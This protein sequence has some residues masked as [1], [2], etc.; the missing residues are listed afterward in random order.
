MNTS[1]ILH[2]FP[3]NGLVKKGT[4]LNPTQCECNQQAEIT[5]KDR[6]A[7]L[8]THTSNNAVVFNMTTSGAYPIKREF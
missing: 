3:L 1:N 5:I 8:F 4:N 7:E 6:I 2:L